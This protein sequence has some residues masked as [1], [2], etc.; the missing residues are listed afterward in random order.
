MAEQDQDGQ[1]QCH[2]QL[3]AQILC[4]YMCECKKALLCAVKA[5]SLHVH[6]RASTAMCARVCFV[7]H[8]SCQAAVRRLTTRPFDH[9]GIETVRGQRWFRPAFFIYPLRSPT[10]P[11]VRQLVTYSDSGG[12]WWGPPA[13]QSV[14]S[15]QLLN[16]AGSVILLEFFN[17]CCAHVSKSSCFFVFFLLVCACVRLCVSHKGCQTIS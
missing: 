4:G 10:D 2:S 17:L 15:L 16:L 6:L 11:D 12:V 7:S 14:L 3:C 13:V 1:P 9:Y 8:P 5:P